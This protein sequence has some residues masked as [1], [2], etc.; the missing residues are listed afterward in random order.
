[1]GSRAREGARADRPS[2]SAPTRRGPSS[3]ASSARSS[4]LWARTSTSSSRTTV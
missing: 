1:V 4:S 2:G 3:V